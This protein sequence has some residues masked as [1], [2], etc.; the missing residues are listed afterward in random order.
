MTD[1]DRDRFRVLI[2]EPFLIGHRPEYVRYIIEELVN[3]EPT[4]EI[5][6]LTDDASPSSEAHRN[7]CHGLDGAFRTWTADFGASRVPLPLPGKGHIGLQL[8]CLLAARRE[9]ARLSSRRPYD[10]VIVPY[11][12]NFGH[13]LTVAAWSRLFSGTPWLTLRVNCRYHRV[14][15]SSAWRERLQ[16]AIDRA[17]FLTMLRDRSLRQV[18]VIDPELA[19]FLGHPKI[20]YVPDPAACD[21]GTPEDRA[22]ARAAL[23]LPDDIPAIL[24]YGTLDRRK[25]LDLLIDAAAEVNDVTPLIVVA[26]GELDDVV[27]GCLRGDAATRLRDLDR[28]RLVGR[29]VTAEEEMQLFRAADLV[30]VHYDSHPGSS[31]A[32]VR[33]GRYGVPIVANDVGLVG[34]TVARERLG[35]AVP[36]GD[37]PRLVSGIIGLCRDHGLRAAIGARARA[38]FAGHDPGCF[39]RV[40]VGE[41]VEHG[42]GRLPR[43]LDGRWAGRCSGR[44]L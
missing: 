21:V 43:P 7:L 34:E 5:D 16:Q 37:K 28:L 12:E 31:G 27:R 26:A 3:Q 22:R 17:L 41:V 36:H 42:R 13:F 29:F 20:R 35:V 30:W 9:H 44:S 32:Y 18:Y 1:G 2:I 6:L 38:L 23:G 40:I 33:A 10:H 39:A 25:R 24:V 19:R 4:V 11:W 8:G 14:G 15:P